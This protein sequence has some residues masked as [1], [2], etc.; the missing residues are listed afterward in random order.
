MW[1]L[2][3]GSAPV[4]GGTFTQLLSWRWCFWINLPISL[5]AFILL[6]LFLDVHDPKTPL[7]EGLK[8]ID[9]LGSFSILG[10]TVMLFLGLQFGGATFAW[11]SWQ[12]VALIAIGM[13]MLVS[14]WYIE[15][16]VAKHPLIPMDLLTSWTNVSS[17]L[18]C[19]FHGMVCSVSQITSSHHQT[20]SCRH[21]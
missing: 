18:V 13:L 11:N 10:F 1:T 7:L 17:L 6:L 14:F 8:A 3:G 9:W 20:D 4:L 21:S 15:A 12:V 2:A 16:R 5:T 19:F